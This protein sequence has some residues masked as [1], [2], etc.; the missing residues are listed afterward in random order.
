[1]A[2][3]LICPQRVSPNPLMEP[4]QWA[5]Q[6]GEFGWPYLERMLDA[7]S[8]ED[9]KELA[10]RASLLGSVAASLEGGRPPQ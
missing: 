7:L 8:A 2:T 9:Y 10:Y 4:N 3:Y 1:M 5:E 6:R